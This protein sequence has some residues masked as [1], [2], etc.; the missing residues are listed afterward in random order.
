MMVKIM[1]HYK[2]E[3][4]GWRKGLDKWYTLNIVERPYMNT[5]Y[6]IWLNSIGTFQ[7]FDVFWIFRFN[8]LVFKFWSFEHV[9]N[10]NNEITY[11]VTHVQMISLFTL[12][13]NWTLQP[14]ESCSNLII[15]NNEDNIIINTNFIFDW[16]LKYSNYWI[17]TFP[18]KITI[19][20]NLIINC[21]SFIMFYSIKLKKKNVKKNAH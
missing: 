14:Y 11:Y 5:Y 13:H 20:N 16:F 7:I 19:K 8:I 15:N 9:T 3:K 1:K 12:W 18:K 6:S 21:W 2:V 4:L 10:I 17:N